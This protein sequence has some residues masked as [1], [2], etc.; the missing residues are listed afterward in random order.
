MVAKP[1][2]LW[3]SSSQL[4]WLELGPTFESCSRQLYPLEQINL[5]AAVIISGLCIGRILLLAG[6][7][8]FIA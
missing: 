8:G 7:T 5:A 3:R 4:L 1:S 2:N 6:G